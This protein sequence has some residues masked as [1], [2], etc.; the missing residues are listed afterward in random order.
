M[1]DNNQNQDD[2]GLDSTIMVAIVIGATGLVL[3]VLGGVYYLTR[4]GDVPSRKAV[5]NASDEENAQPIV[6][7]DTATAPQS[8][9]AQ[10]QATPPQPQQIPAEPEKT[11]V[12]SPARTVESEPD[13]Q[14]ETE[15]EV[16]EELIEIYAPAG[17]LGVVL[18][19]APE[20]GPPVVHELRSTSVLLG[21]LQVGDRIIAIDDEDVRKLSANRV[22]KLI[23]RKMENATRK[24]SIVRSVFPDV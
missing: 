18:D 21:E 11:A 22:S 10:S 5:A 15:L 20:N 24:F 12:I 7:K 1:D 6:E 23:S 16:R 4:L 3:M 2:G 13:D 14:D 19:T 8:Q 17:K 9:Q